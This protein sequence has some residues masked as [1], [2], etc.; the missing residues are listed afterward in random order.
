MDYKKL[1][2]IADDFKSDGKLSD[3][4]AF[5][6]AIKVMRYDLFRDSFLIDGS[7]KPG[8]LESISMCLGMKSR[9]PD[10]FPL[11]EMAERLTS[12]DDQISDLNGLI[13]NKY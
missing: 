8:A 6:L 1:R 4:E 2:L 9:I 13:E 11:E 10:K 5:D 12:I 3:Y 7:D